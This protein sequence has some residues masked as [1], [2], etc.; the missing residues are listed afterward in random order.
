MFANAFAGGFDE[1][2]NLHDEKILA[3][4]TSQISALTDVIKQK[5]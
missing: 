3:L 1:Q 4:I 5:K 2:G